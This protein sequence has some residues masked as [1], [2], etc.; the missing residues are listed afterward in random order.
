[1]YET[2]LYM[3]LTTLKDDL[4]AEFREERIMI[5]DQLEKL[6]PLATALRCPAAQK[7]LSSSTLFI[8]EF[9]CYVI[10]LGGIAFG[11]LMHR[12]YPFNLL[13]KA[14]YTPEVRNALGGPNLSLLIAA[15]YALLAIGVVGIFVIGRMSREIRLKNEVLHMAGRDVKAIVGQH[16]ERKAALKTIE[17]R[18]LLGLSGVIPVTNPAKVTPVSEVVNA[19]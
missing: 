6:D 14:L 2:L 12:I 18:H 4:L 8:A 17:Q 3:S 9:T 11:A 7:L 19:Y 10:S 5:N 16:L 1:M 13:N 15:T